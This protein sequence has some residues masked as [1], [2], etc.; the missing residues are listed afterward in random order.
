MRT[1]PVVVCTEFFDDA[2]PVAPDA[3]TTPGADVVLARAIEERV[4]RLSGFVRRSLGLPYFPV[5]GIDLVRVEPVPPPGAPDDLVGPSGPRRIGFVLVVGDGRVPEREDRGVVARVFDSEERDGREV[6][7]ETFTDVRVETDS[8]VLFPGGRHVELRG[9][10]P[11]D[12]PVPGRRVFMGSVVAGSTVAPEPTSGDRRSSELRARLLP[13]FTEGGFELRPTPRVVHQFLSSILAMRSAEAIDP[14]LLSDDV[15]DITGNRH[16]VLRALRGSAEHFAG[17]SLVASGLLGLRIHR[18]GDAVDPHL[19]RLETDVITVVVQVALDVDEPW[20]FVLER[21]GVE[22]SVPLSAGQMLL[23]E[24]ATTARSRPRSLRGRSSVSLV[25][26]YRPLDWSW[27]DATLEDAAGSERA[28]TGGDP[29][30]GGEDRSSGSCGV[31]DRGK[32]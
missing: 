32:E 6:A 19:G 16:D 12:E 21:D 3:A 26:T 23:V 17:V 7:A 31:S 13:R 11:F 2:R 27:T 29:F 10:G 24:S 5:E 30:T 14:D 8:V 20:S 15:V 9:I 1:T 4:R 18:E 25:A 28:L 22:R